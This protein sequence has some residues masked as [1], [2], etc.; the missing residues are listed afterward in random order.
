MGTK[1]LRPY[2]AGAKLNFAVPPCFG[3]IAPSYALYR[4]RPGGFARVLGRWGTFCAGRMPCSLGHTL[5]GAAWG[6][7]LRQCTVLL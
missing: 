6:G 1:K 4:E 3:A 7:G 2:D 5:W